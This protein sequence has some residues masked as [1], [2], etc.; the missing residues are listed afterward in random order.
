MRWAFRFLTEIHTSSAISIIWVL[1]SLPEDRPCWQ[2]SAGPSQL[3]LSQ[4]PALLSLSHF[5][6]SLAGLRR[7]IPLSALHFCLSRQLALEPAAP[8]W[9]RCCSGC[10]MLAP[11]LSESLGLGLWNREV[12]YRKP[13]YLIAFLQSAVRVLRFWLVGWRQQDFPVIPC[14]LS[15]A[16]MLDRV[17]VT[18]FVSFHNGVEIGLAA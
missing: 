18:W 3:P 5:G 7:G 4:N 16:F 10:L 15:N 2:Q 13:S 9:N 12:T 1:F 11:F 8:A 14:P 6:L 17:S